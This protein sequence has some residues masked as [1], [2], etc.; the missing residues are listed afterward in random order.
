MSGP[1]VVPDGV[2]VQSTYVNDEG[3]EA[4]WRVWADGRHEGRRS[5]GSWMAGPALDG[6]RIEELRAIL[7]DAPLEEVA[8][9]HE[10]AVPTEHQGTLFF[11]VARPEGPVTVT[12]IGGA[13]VRALERLTERL[14]PILA[15]PP[16][17]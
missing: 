16:R 3:E 7:D 1:P 6:R 10:P 17:L 14:A 9:V 8:G 11:Q 12:A 2:L 5:G 15:R 4:G 13:R